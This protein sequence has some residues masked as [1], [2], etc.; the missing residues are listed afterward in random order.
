MS[1][2]NYLSSDTT[3]LVQM[4]AVANTL[5]D[6]DAAEIPMITV[7]NKIDKL[8]IPESTAIR[9]LVSHTS[10]AVA[11]SC[12]TE[13]GMGEFGAIVEEILS[14]LLVDI[15]VVL[16]YDR[17]DLANKIFEGGLVQP[18]EYKEEGIF[19]KGRVSKEVAKRVEQFSMK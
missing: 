5:E 1:H 14:G 10:H 4:E 8:T 16:P 15:D 17:G 12:T 9:N 2:S 19:I 3:L 7:Y 13:E 6:I 11:V 18:P